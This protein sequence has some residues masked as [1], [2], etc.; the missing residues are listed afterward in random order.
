M[1]FLKVKNK[2]DINYSMRLQNLI[3]IVANSVD[4]YRR[5]AYDDANRQFDKTRRQ[6]EDGLDQDFNSCRSNNI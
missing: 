3:L 4:R 6:I 2:S 1:K 5:D